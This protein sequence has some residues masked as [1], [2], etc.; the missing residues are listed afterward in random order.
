MMKASSFIL[1]SYATLL[2]CDIEIIEKLF[3]TEDLK[4]PRFSESIIFN[5]LHNALLFYKNKNSPLLKLDRHNIN[6]NNASSS[7]KTDEKKANDVRPVTIIGD[8]HGNLHDLLRIW[9]SVGNIFEK[10]ILFLG[11]FV[12]RGEFQLETI[13]LLLAL[14]LEYPDFV[15]LI[16]GNHEFAEVNSVQNSRLNCFLQEI[17]NSGYSESLYDKFN[18]VFNWLPIACVIDDTAFC[19]HGGISPQLCNVN[20]IEELTLPITSFTDQ[21]SYK[22]NANFVTDHNNDEVI[23]KCNSDSKAAKKE[24][25]KT[26]LIADLMWSDPTKNIPGYI[27]SGRGIGKYYGY[28][29]TRHFLSLNQMKYIIRAHQ[30][31]E[32]GIRLM[33]DGKC[34]TVFSSSGYSN[35]N[36]CGY[37]ELDSNDEIQK[38]RLKPIWKVMRNT[39]NFIHLTPSKKPRGYHELQTVIS[40][41]YSAFFTFKT[42]KSTSTDSSQG[43]DA[44]NIEDNNNKNSQTNN[45]YKTSI[46]LNRISMI[47]SRN[48]SRSNSGMKIFRPAINS[49]NF[50]IKRWKSRTPIKPVSMSQNIPS[51]LQEPSC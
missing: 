17:L 11:D 30:N 19:V 16:R 49:H 46:S 45:Q 25:L 44:D 35:E 27:E 13:T 32:S 2:N 14:K 20:Q 8:L 7:K 47:D 29:A 41:S 3:G 51:F 36:L 37:I 4:I 18:E 28:L 43:Y 48:Y 23:F 10:R 50:S 1:N 6:K 38:F 40:E 33:H 21:P 15:Y 26:E 9:I 42:N 31:I 5:L 22:Q 39:A 34:I 12:D 24:S